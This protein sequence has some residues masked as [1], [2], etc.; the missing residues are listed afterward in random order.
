MSTNEGGI[1]VGSSVSLTKLMHMCKSQK[2]RKLSIYCA[3]LQQLRWF[4]GNQIR[5]VASLGGN[6]VT[7]SPISDLNP[8]MIAGGAVLRIE[9][10]GTG[11]REVNAGEFFLGYR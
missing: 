3:I 10:K 1:T 6:M 9:G 5:N 2:S 7:G 11:V 4:A 8:L